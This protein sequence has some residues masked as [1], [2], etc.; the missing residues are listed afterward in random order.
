MGRVPANPAYAVYC[1]SLHVLV[2][3]LKMVSL[4]NMFTSHLKSVHGM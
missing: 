3:G 1:F 4:Q 2:A